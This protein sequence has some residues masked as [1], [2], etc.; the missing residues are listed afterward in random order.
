M[1]DGAGPGKNKAALL[2]AIGGKPKGPAGAGGGAADMLEPEADEA[3][4]P[5]MGEMKSMAAADV[6]AAFK[7]GDAGALE[8]ALTDFVRACQSEDY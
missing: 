2:L 1:A 6:M 5:G 3:D 8:T 7:S 4:V